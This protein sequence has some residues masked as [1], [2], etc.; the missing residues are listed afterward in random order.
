MKDM[1]EYLLNSLLGK[2]SNVNLEEREEQDKVYLS[3]KVDPA[4][5]GKVIGKD[6]CIVKA[7]RTVLCA[8]GT[9]KN[10]KVFLKIED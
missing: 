1:A 5:K 10:K 4:A 7:V 6:G 2:D 9:K 8:A 3:T